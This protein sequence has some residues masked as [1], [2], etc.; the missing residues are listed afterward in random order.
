METNENGQVISYEEYH[1]FGTSAYRT[2]KSGTD[3]S[4]KRYRFTNKERDDETG[5]YY[6]GVRYYAAWLGRWT[7]S[8]PGDFVDGLN[9]YVYVRNNPVNG[10]DE[11]GY[12]TEP[13]LDNL[14]DRE[15]IKD[16]KPDDLVDRGEADSVKGGLILLS[17][18]RGSTAT[19][20]DYSDPPEDAKVIRRPTGTAEK[21]SFEYTIIGIDGKASN[22]RRGSKI[23]QV[24]ET[25]YNATFSSDANNDYKTTFIGYFDSE[26]NQ[27]EEETLLFE[28]KMSDSF[29][30]KLLEVS[31]GLGHD[32]NKL[33][34]VMRHENGANFPNASQWDLGTGTTAV[35]LIQFTQVAIDEMNSRYQTTYT[36]TGLSQMTEVGQLDV[37]KQYYEMYSH[38][39]FSTLIDYAL[40]TFAPAYMGSSASTG[41]YT[42]AESGRKY[43]ANISLDTDSNGIITAGEIGFKY[44]QYYK[45]SY[46]RK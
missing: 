2:A 1:P 16:V 44:K 45:K 21:G 30:K 35:G 25:T 8:D 17:S 7:S 34:A 24:G 36:K 13:I 29:K 26:G 11:L 28:Y 15:Q 9:L 22:D 42:K 14:V 3:L 23:L 19:D 18:D 41:L 10:V 46:Q 20:L 43:S 27:Y 5:L 37:V 40:A 31:Y 6:F 12:S 38:K 39:N 33:V 32:P 4:L